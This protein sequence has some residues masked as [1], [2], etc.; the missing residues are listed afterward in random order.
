MPQNKNINTDNQK[1]DSSDIQQNHI[2]EERK[3]L[4][5]KDQPTVSASSPDQSNQDNNKA[6]GDNNN[7]TK[8]SSDFSEDKHKSSSVLFDEPSFSK[9]RIKPPVDNIDIINGIITVTGPIVQDTVNQFA[10][11]MHENETQLRLENR[12][13]A[14][15][16]SF[17]S[18][19]N[20]II[21]SKIT[22]TLALLGNIQFMEFRSGRL[23]I[24]E[25][26]EKNPL[27]S[28]HNL[29]HIHT[30]G[31]DLSLS[32]N[33]GTAVV[34]PYKDT[35]NIH[36][37][38]GTKGQRYKR[39]DNTFYSNLTEINTPVL[40]GVDFASLSFTGNGVM[41][42]GANAAPTRIV[43]LD[44]DSR[45]KSLLETKIQLNAP[46]DFKQSYGK[47][48]R[49][50]F[51][52]H[53]SA[54][55]DYRKWNE[56]GNAMKYLFEH[57]DHSYIS[58]LFDEK[59][60]KIETD[61]IKEAINERDEEKQKLRNDLKEK[62]EKLA[63]EEKEDQ[64][65][66][67]LKKIRKLQEEANEKIKNIENPES[68]HEKDR[69]EA[70]RWNQKAKIISDEIL[71]KKF[72]S[73]VNLKDETEGEEIKKATSI[74]YDK[75][76][77]NKEKWI[78][79]L[80]DSAND[81]ARLTSYAS[82]DPDFSKILLYLFKKNEK[83]NM[84]LRFE[85]ELNQ[86]SDNLYTFRE[87]DEN[88]KYSLTVKEWLSNSEA[89]NQSENRNFNNSK[90]RCDY[91]S[92]IGDSL[93]EIYKYLSDKKDDISNEAIEIKS[94]AEKAIDDLQKLIYSV[95]KTKNSLI[96]AK[97][98][99]IA[100]N[101]YWQGKATEK[102]SNEVLGRCLVHNG[103]TA[104]GEA[105]LAGRDLSQGIYNG[106][107]SNT[108]LII[109]ARYRLAGAFLDIH[110]KFNNVL[111]IEKDFLNGNHPEYKDSP[112]LTVAIKLRE[113]KE[114]TALDDALFKNLMLS[115]DRLL[116]KESNLRDLWN[117]RFLELYSD[118]RDIS[119]QEA[120]RILNEDTDV[121]EATDEYNQAFNEFKKTSDD[122]EEKYIRD[123]VQKVDKVLALKIYKKGERKLLRELISGKDGYIT[124]DEL[125][126]TPGC[127]EHP[128]DANVTFLPIN[129]AYAKAV[130]AH[131]EGNTHSLTVTQG[132]SIRYGSFAQTSGIK[133]ILEK[134][135]EQLQ[136]EYE[137]KVHE[138]NTR[139]ATIKQSL[140]E[141][142]ETVT[143]KALE[144]DD[145]SPRKFTESL[146]TSYT[147][148]V[149]DDYTKSAPQTDNKTLLSAPAKQI[150]DNAYQ[151]VA[152]SIRQLSEDKAWLNTY[153]N[154]Q[155]YAISRS[156][157]GLVLEDRLRKMIKKK[158][159][160][161]ERSTSTEEE[162]SKA[163]ND[164]RQAEKDFSDFRESRRT[165]MERH[166][167]LG[168]DVRCIAGNIKPVGEK[169]FTMAT[170]DERNQYRWEHNGERMPPLILQD[171]DGIPY[172][173]AGTEEE[174]DNFMDSDIMAARIE[175]LAEGS[176]ERIG[177]FLKNFR[178]MSVEESLIKMVA[179]SLLMSKNV[180]KFVYSK[181]EYEVAKRL[182]ERLIGERILL[183]NKKLLDE[184]ANGIYGDSY[185]LEKKGISYGRK[186]S[187]SS[188][189][190]RTCFC[191]DLEIATDGKYTGR[192]FYK[193]SKFLGKGRDNNSRMKEI[194]KVS[195]KLK[196]YEDK[197]SK[198]EAEV[199][200][201]QKTLENKAAQI[202]AKK[203]QDYAAVE[204][205]KDSGKLE[206]SGK[207]AKSMSSSGREL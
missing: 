147:S 92:V 19:S 33:K 42:I 100:Q 6:N 77:S 132:S 182:R 13:P 81:I 202:R 28:F 107:K 118:K 203:N 24:S 174:M 18:A 194:Q 32:Y 85:L 156:P 53:K 15:G 192:E 23:K 188:R 138:I 145:F 37:S 191:V 155:D 199:L 14:T 150:A 91:L 173:T 119:S 72:F 181:G 2:S 172:K 88:G 137:E 125:I 129:I 159:E 122:I 89:F 70:C 50:Y 82:R 166:S 64:K 102:I 94:E 168:S 98:D 206:K 175:A 195:D 93:D 25:N 176:K 61:A 139:D 49:E 104:F 110:E 134:K 196:K 83:D 38:I 114:Q 148:K 39:E 197:V 20:M 152:Q 142:Y 40:A 112:E 108:K 4:K 183:E 58:K 59:K 153:K 79:W 140:R 116:H 16:L 143:G 51:L 161:F 157:R 95:N 103:N 76:D 27:L 167:I 45:E 146:F 162:R 177:I 200:E 158:S 106:D 121:K 22:D 154:W 133:A 67:S 185:E 48:L 128:E 78:N 130:I 198:K 30:W 21:D 164:A 190:K 101:L 201:K 71:S 80:R 29:A 120:I 109:E 179:L 7:V 124:G 207:L 75:F 141:L 160:V 111:Q 115:K 26:T 65:E 62:S 5:N 9:L 90:K 87:K 144:D 8:P 55:F 136:T 169:V 10:L 180:L 1:T 170:A 189:N 44:S 117:K 69:L 178:H 47:V 56:L 126:N 84:R 204:H 123:V 35:K 135:D 97:A 163:E 99:E 151:I 12:Y 17:N 41:S 73:D 127:D 54:E 186:N 63:E 131:A 57:S 187:L 43:N 86:L 66:E 165:I 149:H 105:S 113:Y 171:R 36:F 31:G 68:E 52:E 34:N 193:I 184:T 96:K 46:P 74:S 205:A 3:P 60:E 11:W